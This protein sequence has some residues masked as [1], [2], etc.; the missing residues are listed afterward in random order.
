MNS[1]VSLI[2]CGWFMTFFSTSRDSV[3][4]TRDKPRLRLLIADDHAVFAEVLRAQLEKTFDV[5][6]IA[7]DG[8]TLLAEA[9]RLKPDLAVIDV[10]MPLLNGLEAARRM[11]EQNPTL[12]LVFLTMLN[13][14]NLAAAALELGKVGFVLKHSAMRELLT[15]IEHVLRNESYLTPALRAEDWVEHQTRVRQFSKA[16]T[17][18]QLDVVQLFSEGWSNQ[19]IA[20]Y[21][22]LSV[23]TI[24]FHKLPRQACIQ[25][26][27]QCG[28]GVVCRQATPDLASS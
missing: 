26:E 9:A 27:K 8:R 15:A 2:R 1:I 18:R 6:G 3:E 7:L 21:L 23:K 24:E 17:A 5:V 25:F 22:D 16:L 28:P 4:N 19:Q 14:P 13:D 10:I 12:K 11:K 20:D